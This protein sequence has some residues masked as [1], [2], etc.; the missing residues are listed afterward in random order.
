M[1]DQKIITLEL[2]DE[3]LAELDRLKGELG[4]RSHGALVERLLEELL[5]PSSPGQEI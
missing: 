5:L 4:L 2:H 3:L 1:N